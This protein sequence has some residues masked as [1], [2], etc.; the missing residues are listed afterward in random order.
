[1]IGETW[2]LYVD[3]I[4]DQHV[5]GDKEGDKEGENNDKEKAGQPS[6]L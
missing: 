2:D 1:L 4:I 6:F 5:V 3:G